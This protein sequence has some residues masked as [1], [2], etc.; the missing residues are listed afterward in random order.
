MES[1]LPKCID[2]KDRGILRILNDYINRQEWQ[3]KSKNNE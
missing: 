2:T 1:K 3:E